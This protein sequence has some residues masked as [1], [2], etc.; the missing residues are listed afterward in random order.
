M[1]DLTHPVEDHPPYLVG[2]TEYRADL[3]GGMHPYLTSQRACLVRSD[4]SGRR[5]LAE[6]LTREPNTW[7]SFAGWSPDGRLAIISSDWENPEN[8]AWEE[9]HQTF[10][11]TEGWRHDQCLLDL[12]TG[13]LANVTAVER[14]SDYNAGLFFWLKDSKRLGFEALIGGISTPFSM[15]L[16]GT[17]KRDLSSGDREFTYGLNASPDGSRIAYHK[18]YQVYIADADGSQAERVDTGQPFNF[19]PRW[20][21]DGQWLLFLSGE[22]YDCHACLVRP[23]GS[24]LRKLADRHGYRGVVELLDIPAFHSA[25]SDIPVWAPDGRWVY[26]AAKCGESVELMRVGLDG[27][28]QRLTRSERGTLNY[29]PA[30]S[31]DGMWVL[32]GSNRAGARRLYALR[33]DGVG[34]YPLTNV[35]TGYGAAHGHWQPI[36]ADA[37]TVR[38]LSSQDNPTRG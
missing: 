25:S 4:G 18:S 29:H 6:E 14:V 13:G 31:P 3:P 33:A 35:P 11:M 2:Y 22:H 20:S 17:N 38:P 8:A 26:Y 24:G 30:P 27:T 23:D 15:S 16:D 32:F 36:A 37:W 21:P 10:R 7:T 34:C 28:V 19:C 9:K 5:Q 1:Q 12:A